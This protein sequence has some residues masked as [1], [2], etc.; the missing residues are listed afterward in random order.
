MNKQTKYAIFNKKNGIIFDTVED[1]SVAEKYNKE[2]FVIKEIELGPSEYY[3]GDYETGKVYDADDIPFIREDEMEEK[4]FEGIQQKYS[5][6]KQIMIII[7]VIKQ[8]N[9]IVKTDAFNELYEFL[10]TQKIR[11]DA[12]LEVIKNDKES[13]NF[14]S[15]EDIKNI[16]IKRAEGIVV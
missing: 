6:I 1:K 14:I 8:N 15:I 2:H 12:Q 3:F 4:F 11:Y 9:D 5:I 13:F 16:L 10:R 7:D